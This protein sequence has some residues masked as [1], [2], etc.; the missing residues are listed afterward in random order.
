MCHLEKRT[1]LD[2]GMARQK[3]TIVHRD[4]DVGRSTGRKYGDGAWKKQGPYI[5]L[6]F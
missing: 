6:D 1:L 5:E 2:G 4:Q 3:E